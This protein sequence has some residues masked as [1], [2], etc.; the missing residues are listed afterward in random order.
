MTELCVRILFFLGFVTPY[1]LL[2]TKKQTND[3]FGKQQVH[4]AIMG[5]LSC[6]TKHISC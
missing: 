5:L 4:S 6:L 2:E 3:N 1:G